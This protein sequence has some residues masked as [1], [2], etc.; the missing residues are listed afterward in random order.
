MT[1]EVIDKSRDVYDKLKG[2]VGDKLQ[3]VEDKT[4]DMKESVV[5]KYE[6]AKDKV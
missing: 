1:D 2:S 3:Q 4:R 6:D 5:D